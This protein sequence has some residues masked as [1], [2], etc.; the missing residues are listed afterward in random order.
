MDKTF[1]VNFVQ[2]LF[3]TINGGNLSLLLSVYISYGCLLG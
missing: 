2:F 1:A 3:I